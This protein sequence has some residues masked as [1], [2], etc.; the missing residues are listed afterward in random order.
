MLRNNFISLCFLFAISGVLLDC[1][2]YIG[3]EFQTN[4]DDTMDEDSYILA[5]E[6]REGIVV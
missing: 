1:E 3:S 2:F 4:V 6:P 5:G